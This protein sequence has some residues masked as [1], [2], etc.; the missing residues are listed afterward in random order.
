MSFPIIAVSVAVFLTGYF[1]KHGIP[2]FIGGFL[3]LLGT[4]IM[5]PLDIIACLGVLGYK[6]YQYWET[7][8]RW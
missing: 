1:M 7:G 8:K 3:M 2:M 5:S 6:A 4:G